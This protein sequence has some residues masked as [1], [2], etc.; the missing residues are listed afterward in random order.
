MAGVLEYIL[1]PRRHLVRDDLSEA[2]ID[3]KVLELQAAT[4]ILAEV[5]CTDVSEIGEMLKRRYDEG[6]HESYRCAGQRQSLLKRQCC[7]TEAWP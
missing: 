6:T 7:G 3:P 5:F 1:R 2:K 4:E